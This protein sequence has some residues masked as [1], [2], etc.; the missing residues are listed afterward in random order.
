M[1]APA[2]PGA[3]TEPVYRC[4]S[5]TQDIDDS[6]YDGPWPDN[7]KITVKSCAARSGGTVYAYAEATWDGTAFRD[8]NN[9]RIFDG[10]RLRLQIK[11]SRDGTD[12][13]VTE[14][15]FTEIERRLED[16][17]SGRNY[18]GCC[19]T[20]SIRHRVGLWPLACSVLFLDWHGDGRSYGRHDHTASP[21]V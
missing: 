3:A 19:R 8:V 13:V 15:D 20:R 12:P 10:A 9:V 14:R 16:S 1:T 11:A 6:S 5:S 4:A 17:T 18:D 7:W 21:T 2:A